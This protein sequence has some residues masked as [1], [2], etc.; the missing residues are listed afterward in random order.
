MADDTGGGRAAIQL[1][2]S[3]GFYGAEAV[4]LGLAA[5]LRDRGWRSAVGVLKSPGAKGVAERA[6][7]EGLPVFPLSGDPW[8]A[9]RGLRAVLARERFDLVHTHGYKTDVVAA[10]P[11]PGHVRRVATCHGWLSDS[12]KL[13]AFERL[14]RL[15][16]RRF[17]H[18]VAVSAGVMRTLEASGI[19]ADRRSLVNNG[20]RV[21]A[22]EPAA[23]E[24]VRAELLPPG[25]GRLAV[26]IGR[27]DGYKGNDIL[28]EAMAFLPRNVD[29]RLAF[30]GEGEP[31]H[32]LH[33]KAARLGL[34]DRVSFPG[35]RE[36]VPEVLAA[37]D[38]MVISSTSESLPMVMLEAMA[39]GLPIVSTSAGGIPSVLRDGETAWLVPPGDAIA[40]MRALEAALADPGERARRARAA[41]QDYASS[42]SREA[43]G[44]RYEAVYDRVLGAP[45]SR[46]VT[47]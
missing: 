37:A 25:A 47:A 46:T 2:S 27:L 29:V 38:L 22:V 36:D 12:L 9:W 42:Y 21:R 34:A 39:A 5:H 43:M 32:R 45:G 15:A 44:L 16:L 28:L 20:V 23:R 24:R 26:R 19:P 33:S 1:V 17:D 3:G 10:L 35:Y 13:G 14:D 30:V 8:G 40:L 41:R 31:L 6:A 18:V 4:L 7:S 11:L